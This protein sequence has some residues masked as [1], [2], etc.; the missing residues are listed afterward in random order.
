MKK[1]AIRLLIVFIVVVLLVLVSLG[2][3]LDAAIKRGIETAGPMV[4]KVPIKLDAVSLS[5]F[6]GS[7]RIKGL[8]VGNPEGYKTPSAI[9][10]GEASIALEPGSV[11][12]HKVIIKS[13]SLEAPEVTFETNLKENNLSKILANL[14]AATGSESSGSSSS[15]PGKK[16]QVDDF[17]IR[18]AKLNVSLTAL[19]KS[20]TVALPEIHLTQ[21]GAGPEGITPAELAQ[22]VLQAIEKEAAQASTSAIAGLAKDATGLSK[23]LGKTATGAAEKIS[24]GL[25]GLFKKK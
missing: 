22:Q 17:V 20:A 9:Q 18:N 16:L 11:F 14:Q 10:V 7:G 13:I 3:F 23:D 12:S 4:A 8:V 2:L 21:L 19:G 25:G 6:S 1:I 24:Q 15:K 5:F